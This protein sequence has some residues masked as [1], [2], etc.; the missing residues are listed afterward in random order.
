MQAMR[1]G[2][3]DTTLARLAGAGGIDAAGQDEKKRPS[4]TRPGQSSQSSATVGRPMSSCAAHRLTSSI[5]SCVRAYT[6]LHL[7]PTDPRRARASQLFLAQATAIAP[8]QVAN[9]R[10]CCPPAAHQCGKDHTT[11]RT[12]AAVMTRV[13]TEFV[14]EPSQPSQPSESPASP[15]QLRAALQLRRLSPTRRLD[16]S[17][18]TIWPCSARVGTSTHPNHTS[19]L[20]ALV[21]VN[22]KNQMCGLGE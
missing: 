22:E 1:A 18:A 16:D 9:H 8:C 13:F 11:A 17:P 3:T 15:V 14:R 7:L 19:P 4:E 5:S 12:P 2:G 20:L 6:Y 10:H 21:P